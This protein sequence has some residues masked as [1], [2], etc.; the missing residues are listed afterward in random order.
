M[1]SCRDFVDK[2]PVGRF[3][4]D[5]GLREMWYN[6]DMKSTILLAAA[7]LASAAFADNAAAAKSKDPK[8]PAQPDFSVVCSN[9][10]LKCT[11]DKDPLGYAAGD[12]AKFEISFM[13][14]TNAVPEGKYKFKWTAKGF[15]EA[16]P[17]GSVELSKKKLVFTGK[18]AEPGFA[19]LDVQVVDAGGKPFQRV[20]GKSKREISIACGAGAD[21]LSLAPPPEP[22]DLARRIKDMKSKL[23]K[24]APKKVE[25]VEIPD[26]GLSGVK[27]YSVTVPF[28][29]DK[30]LKGI[31]LLPTKIAEG[32]KVPMRLEFEPCDLTKPQPMPGKNRVPQGEASFFM[33]FQSAP[34]DARDDAYCTDLY[35]HVVR[36]LQFVH[37][38]PEWNGKEI[39]VRGW[40][41]QGTLA[42]WAASCGEGVTSVHCGLLLRDV[43][44]EQFDPALMARAVP[45]KCL[46]DV[47]RAG[48]GDDSHP[49][50]DTVRIWNALKCDKRVLWVQGC[51]GWPSPPRYKER[52]ILWEKIHPMAYRNMDAEHCKPIKAGSDH[53]F[54][55]VDVA[56]KNKVVL[57]VV[58]DY[59]KPAAL[60]ADMLA[61][62]I[63]YAKKDLKPLTIYVTMPVRKVKDKQWSK[64]IELQ[65]KSLDSYP[66]YFNAGMDLPAPDVMPW[67]RVVDV[68]GVL[69]YSGPKMD[70]VN[71]AIS[72]CFAA[73]PK[74]DPVFSLARPVLLK[75]EIAKISKSTHSGAKLY[76]S[77]EGLSRKYARSNRDMSA[78]ADRLLVGM[79]QAV[80][81]RIVDISNRF[82]DRPGLAYADMLA[83]VKEW[84][85][86][87]THHAI[88]HLRS[89]VADNSSIEKLAKMEQELK[90]LLGW[91][92][93]KPSDV[94][95][96]D[97]ALAALK[98]KVDRLVKSKDTQTQGEAMVMAAEIENP[99]QPPQPP[100]Q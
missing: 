80:E 70:A 65:G 6:R 52:D 44:S 82:S 1:P 32:A 74:P 75:D 99:P 50:A 66:F 86:L 53:S 26:S 25:R 77:I 20:V 10:W 89:C 16:E 34:K 30:P 67:Y 69:R 97:A 46:V 83:L 57:E 98:A 9:A 59:E 18:I 76:K 12:I 37:T 4:G 95:K 45:E 29:K 92:P 87:E 63:H 14:V 33:A 41:F 62:L 13:G 22:K 88:R 43:A 84:P 19:R 21:V 81:T 17:E 78:E 96:K 72:R 79:R 73:V 49:P 54:K 3:C 58:F 94:K 39:D 51:S 24:L 38:V 27:A 35:L 64:F 56:L 5:D 36:A 7:L 8:A 23:A 40:E 15:A 71:S 85:N 42:L 90:H 28:E 2:S 11:T 68:D 93:E 55:D 91:F 100:Q 48:L 31:L 60:S 61:N 47:L